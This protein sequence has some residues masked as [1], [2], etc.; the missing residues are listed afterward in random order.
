MR[1]IIYPQKL[2]D[3][4]SPHAILDPDNS[5][6]IELL[7]SWMGVNQPMVAHVTST[8][9]HSH[10]WDESLPDRSISGRIFPAGK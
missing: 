5:T 9:H 7:P 1:G 8:A 10:R 3:T 6:S 4:V 2:I